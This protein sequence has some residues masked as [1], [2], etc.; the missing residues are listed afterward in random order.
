MTPEETLVWVR[1]RGVTISLNPNCDGL[2]LRADKSVPPDVVAVVKAA[3]ADIVA[4][5]RRREALTSL[6]ERHRPLLEA[7][8]DARPP[9]VDDALWETAKRGLRAFIAAG[10][11]DEAER[12]GWPRDELYAVPPLWA[13]VDLCGAALLIGDR[14]VADITPNAIQIRTASGATQRFFRRPEIDIGLVHSERFKI[15][16]RNV[17]AAEAHARSYDYAIS[18]HRSHY[19]S[20]LEAAKRA[21]MAAIKR[22]AAP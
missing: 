14:E 19:G 11:G 7:V 20:D 22:S 21:V 12:L 17:D 18:V 5:L 13:R 9:D 2:K 1:S 8:D 16:S 3:K 10:H 4:A 15:L 6:F